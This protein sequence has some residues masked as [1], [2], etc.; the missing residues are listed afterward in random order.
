[1]RVV[2]GDDH[3]LLLEALTVA[4]RA[5]GHEVVASATEPDRIVELVVEQAPDVCLLDLGFPDGS[6]IDITRRILGAA[7]ATKVLVLSAT[8]DPEMVAAA[9]DVGAAGFARKDK[10]VEQVLDALERVEQGETY[11]DPDTLRSLARRGQRRPDTSSPEW[12]AGFLTVREREVLGRIVAGEGTEEM[13]VGMGISRS[14]ARTHA[15]NVL[16]KLGVHSRLQAMALV[17]ANP[18][19][20]RLLP[21]GT[22]DYD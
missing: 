9:I 6:G 8:T 13:A 18:D 15:Q 5:A 22:G 21:T 7:P 20:R 10:P 11:V 12:R 16:Q 2:L 4:L 3:R 1:M 19:M 14:T 17:A